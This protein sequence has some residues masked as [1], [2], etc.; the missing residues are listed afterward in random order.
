MLDKAKIISNL[1]LYFP[2]AVTKVNKKTFVLTT[3]QIVHNF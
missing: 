2:C 3:Y 1:L